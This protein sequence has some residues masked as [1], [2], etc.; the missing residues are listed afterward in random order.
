MILEDGHA[1]GILYVCGSVVGEMLPKDSE[2]CDYRCGTFRVSVFNHY[3]SCAA[4]VSE[5]QDRG[6]ELTKDFSRI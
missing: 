4:K 5:R 3:I 6:I 2:R 1:E